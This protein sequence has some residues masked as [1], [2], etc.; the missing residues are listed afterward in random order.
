MVA[1]EQRMPLLSGQTGSIARRRWRSN[2]CCRKAPSV[3][4]I[5]TFV[6]MDDLEPE[7]GQAGR[8]G[9]GSFQIDTTE[10]NLVS[11]V[12][13]EKSELQIIIGSPCKRIC[14]NFL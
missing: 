4:L 2:D 1:T 12:P 13:S 14:H 9:S 3:P 6:Q 10:R 7:A 8:E 11:G 5:L